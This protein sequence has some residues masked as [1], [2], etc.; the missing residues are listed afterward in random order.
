MKYL[1]THNLLLPSGKGVEEGVQE[2]RVPR[3]R[4][5][6]PAA[7][8]RPS[9]HGA[10]GGVRRDGRGARRRRRPGMNHEC[11]SI[12]KLFTEHPG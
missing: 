4:D 3:V 7:H 8:R 2:V 5:G 11:N 10:G 1:L 12:S 6:E 9:H